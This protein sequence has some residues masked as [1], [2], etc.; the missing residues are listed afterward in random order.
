MPLSIAMSAK[1]MLRAFGCRVNQAESDELRGR[2]AAA[3]W[4]EAGNLAEAGLCVV[5]TCTVTRDADRQTLKFLRKA[6]REAPGARLVVTGCLAE[7]APQAVRAAA[8]AAVV[9]GNADKRSIPELLGLGAQEETPF[10]ARSRAFLKI[11][12]GCDGACAYC[13]VPRVRPELASLPAPEVEARLRRLAAAG[14]GEIVL[15]GVRLGRYRWG[16]IDLCGLL[17][18][19]LGLPGNFRIR[20]SSLEIGEAGDRLGELIAGSAG[21]LCPHL[22]LPLQSG[23]DSVLRRMG[24]PYR[25]ADFARR[26]EALRR[27]IPGLAVFTDIITGFP[28]E[29]WREHAESIAFASGPGLRGLHVF[30]YSPREATAAAAMPAQVPPEASR[31]RLEDWRRLDAILR[32]AH[33][34]QAAGQ[35]RVVA[36]LGGGAEGV[37][38][39]FLTVALRGATGPGL[40]RVRLAGRGEAPAAEVLG[41]L[42]Q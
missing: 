20:L 38:E 19:L 24:R 18:R 27:A 39:D 5:N 14:I 35:P 1:Y 9:V 15:C 36:P 16:E 12:D 26:L 3:G 10:P 40:W 21:R 29:S 4:S 8:P 37:T 25:A 31:G 13:V 2:L 33:V 28:G 30:R 32:R 34:E 6:A 41:P 23:S 17:E 22:H 42:A 11:Q 7:R